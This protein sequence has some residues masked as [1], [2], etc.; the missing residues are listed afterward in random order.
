MGSLA[1]LPDC[2]QIR[3]V[4]GTELPNL[5]SKRRLSRLQETFRNSP[6]FSTEGA[7]DKYVANRVRLEIGTADFERN[8]IIAGW[9]GGEF[10]D[11]A[12]VGLLPRELA[13]EAKQLDA[14]NLMRIVGE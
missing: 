13:V 5:Y 1:S 12:L 10:D 14:G 6:N 4:R 3:E 11:E 8:G 2:R 7:R 9:F